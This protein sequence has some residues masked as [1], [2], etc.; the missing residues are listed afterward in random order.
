MSDV[1]SPSNPRKP[2]HTVDLSM[3][4]MRQVV[5]FENK[6]QG[7]IY[8]AGSS[9]AKAVVS[10]QSTAAAEDT[11]FYINPA[12]KK[13]ASFDIVEPKALLDLQRTLDDIGRQVLRRRISSQAFDQMRSEQ[14]G[15]HPSVDSSSVF[16]TTDFDPRRKRFDRSSRDRKRAI[17]AA[18]S[19]DFS[20]DNP[21]TKTDI[22]GLTTQ[23]TASKSRGSAVDKHHMILITSVDERQAKLHRDTRETQRESVTSRRPAA[24]HTQQPLQNKPSPFASNNHRSALRTANKTSNRFGVSHQP[25][26]HQQLHQRKVKTAT[27]EPKDF[28]SMLIAKFNSLN[29]KCRFEHDKSRN[30]LQVYNSLMKKPPINPV[31]TAFEPHF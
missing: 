3:S 15:W 22:F 20:L 9:E 31:H 14:K 28:D 29:K 18:A 25:F 4:K 11:T 10:L 17:T 23:R 6:R 16:A 24:S 26:S 2:L 13:N 19:R 27:S 1:V 8:R 21:S 5:V 12:Y 30:L 7:R